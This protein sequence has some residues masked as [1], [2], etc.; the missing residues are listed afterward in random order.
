MFVQCVVASEVIRISEGVSCRGATMRDV[1]IY[2]V[3]IVGVIAT[4]W[5]GTVGG[6]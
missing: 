6:R 1:G 3:S 4:L 5:S 2:V